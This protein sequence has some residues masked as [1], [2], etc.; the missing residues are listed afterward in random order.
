MSYPRHAH[1]EEGSSHS[2]SMERPNSGPQAA[3][4]YQQ[5]PKHAQEYQR[6]Q[7]GAVP[8]MIPYSQSGPRPTYIQNLPTRPS[9]NPNPSQIAYLPPPGMPRGQSIPTYPAHMGNP[10]A[11]QAGGYGAPMQLNLLQPAPYAQSQPYGNPYLNQPS[12]HPG[13]LQGS[14]LPPSAVQLGATLPGL[15]T[16]QHTYQDQG[17]SNYEESGSGHYAEENVWSIDTSLPLDELRENIRSSMDVDSHIEFIRY[18]VHLAETVPTMESDARIAVKNVELLQTEAYKWVKRL[19]SHGPGGLNGTKTPPCATAM[20][21]LAECHGNGSLGLSVDHEKAFTLYY[22]ASKTGHPNACYRVGVC[23]EL[24]VGTRRDGNKAVHYYKKGASLGD[25]PSMYRL[26]LIYLY[27]DL[28]QTRNPKEGLAILQRAS[29]SA[30]EESPQAL[31]E[32]ALLHEPQESLHNLTVEDRDKVSKIQGLVNP[33]AAFAL[34]LYTQAAQLAYA[35]SQ[36]RLG[37]CFQDGDLNSPINPKASIMWYTR[38]AEQ[39]HPDAELALSGWYLEG[40]EGILPSN[41]TQAYAWARRAADKGLSKAEFAVGYYTEM[42]IGIQQSMTE[43][44]KWYQRY[45]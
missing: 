22:Q 39:G 14:P 38:S 43:A 19:A 21:Y 16:H 29:A 7:I 45:V 44:R 8:N 24:G 13:S 12:S 31:H 11:P 5:Q 26:S 32:L 4:H 18:L 3:Q 10:Y 17:S 25:P 2:D 37:T 42:G 6:Q 20:I 23:H 41:D 27:G 33:D 35:P 28:G 9:Q 15:Q 30:D 34:Q 40:A 1:P 36:Y